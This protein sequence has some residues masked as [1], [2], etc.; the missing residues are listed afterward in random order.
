MVHRD[1]WEGTIVEVDV[2]RRVFLPGPLPCPLE[3]GIVSYWIVPGSGRVITLRTNFGNPCTLGAFLQKA[4]SRSIVNLDS[5][6]GVWSVRGVLDLTCYIEER[7]ECIRHLIQ[8]DWHDK[9][10]SIMAKWGNVFL[11]SSTRGTDLNGVRR[12]VEGI[13]L[14]IHLRGPFLHPRNVVTDT[15]LYT[16]QHKLWPWHCDCEEANVSLSLPQRFKYGYYTKDKPWMTIEDL[17]QVLSTEVDLTSYLSRAPEPPHSRLK[18]EWSLWELQS[19]NWVQIPWN[20]EIRIVLGA[21]SCMDLFLFH[22]GV[23]LVEGAY[24]EGINTSIEGTKPHVATNYVFGGKK[25]EK[26]PG[27]DP[28]LSQAPLTSWIADN[29]KAHYRGTFTA[30]VSWVKSRRCRSIEGINMKV[31][32]DKWPSP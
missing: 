3:Q 12:E 18:W 23:D 26:R 14:K 32:K 4:K 8:L 1:Q 19:W 5:L 10:I 30:L 6:G 25:I 29:C 20:M 24:Q 27:W 7:M 17:F 13:V 11:L 16:L 22:P 31:D 28:C 15:F 2:G 9:F 21:R